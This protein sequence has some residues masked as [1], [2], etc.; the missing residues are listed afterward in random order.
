MTPIIKSTKTT[1][2]LATG[3]EKTEPHDWHLLPVD[4]SDGK[5]PECAAK[6]DPSQPHNAQ[7]LAYQYKFYADSGCTRWPTWADAM[8]HCDDET[9]RMWRAALEAKGVKVDG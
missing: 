5:C 4:T 8:A 7:S 6:H 3:E 9:K 2:N 1:V